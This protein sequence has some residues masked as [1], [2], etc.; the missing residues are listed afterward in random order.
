[1][2]SPVDNT[3]AEDTNESFHTPIIESQQKK[4]KSYQKYRR[5]NP[6]KWKATCL[7]ATKKYY[8]KQENKT[9]QFLWQQR[10]K[11]ELKNELT[12][13]RKMKEEFQQ[14]KIVVKDLIKY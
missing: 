13:L 14:L 10:K 5:L 4:E 9:K 1:M 3:T 12:E 2:N 8:S 7:K 11:L 6:E